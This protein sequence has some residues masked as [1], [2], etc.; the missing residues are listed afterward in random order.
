MKLCRKLKNPKSSTKVFFHRAP[1]SPLSSLLFKLCCSF[2]HF[3]DLSL[4][5][6]HP[7]NIHQ[8]EDLMSW[9]HP[10]EEKV[11]IMETR[12]NWK[13]CQPSNGNVAIMSWKRQWSGRPAIMKSD[14][15][16]VIAEILLKWK[17]EFRWKS[18]LLFCLPITASMCG[19]NLHT[20]PFSYL[21]AVAFLSFRQS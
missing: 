10:P 2:F 11:I 1:C 21:S 6:R 3:K 13:I 14:G 15:K 7:W 8:L 19:E 5:K 12:V 9:K 17:L 16:P 4:W 20:S 18:S